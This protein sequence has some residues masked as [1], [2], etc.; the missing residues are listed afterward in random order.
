MKQVKYP[1]LLNT[2]NSNF[3]LTS[4]QAEIEKLEAWI[5]NFVCSFSQ[6]KLQN[7]LSKAKFLRRHDEAWKFQ[8]FQVVSGLAILITCDS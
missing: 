5:R 1:H 3:N 7:L 6:G 2:N 4:A 8:P